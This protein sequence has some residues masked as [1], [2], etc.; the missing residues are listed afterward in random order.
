MVRYNSLVPAIL[1]VFHYWRV[2]RALSWEVDEK[3]CIA[4]HAHTEYIYM[5]VPYIHNPRSAQK[6]LRTQ[7]KKGNGHLGKQAMEVVKLGNDEEE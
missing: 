7:L 1:Q 4:A 5:Y 3:L 2:K 6:I